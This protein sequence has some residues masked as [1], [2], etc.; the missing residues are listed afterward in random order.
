MERLFTR[1]SSTVLANITIDD[2]EDLDDF[3]V[4]L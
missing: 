3:E 4:H 1:A 2:L